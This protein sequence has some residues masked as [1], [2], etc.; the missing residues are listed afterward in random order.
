VL[1]PEPHAEQAERLWLALARAAP[2]P[3]RAE[4]ACLL[5]LCAYLRGSGALA[6]IALQAA[7]DADPT[8]HLT[9]LLLAATGQAMAPGE[10]GELVRAASLQAR[11][12]LLGAEPA[13]ATGA[14]G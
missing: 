14:C 6:N 13:P 3:E 1:W 9:R 12:E 5:G 7:Q 4:P 11:A 10:L 2:A 8:H